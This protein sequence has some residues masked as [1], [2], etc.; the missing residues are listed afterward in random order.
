[1]KKIFPVLLLLALIIASCGRIPEG[2]VVVDKYIV[3]EKDGLRYDPVIHKIHPYKVP[4]R[5]IL[6]VMDS[7]GNQYNYSAC[8]YLFQQVSIGDSLFYSRDTNTMK[9]HN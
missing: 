9:L 1:M 3:A 5:Y 8:E 7:L 4:E 6:V 2:S